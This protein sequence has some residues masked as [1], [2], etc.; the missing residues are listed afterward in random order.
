MLSEP[1]GIQ[2]VETAEAGMNVPDSGKLDFPALYRE[3][4]AIAGR[5]LRNRQSDQ[6][7]QP[8]ALVHEAYLKFSHSAF[9]ASDRTHLL[10]TASTIMRQILVDH[11]RSRQRLKR[12]PNFC[13]VLAESAD[14]I[15]PPVIDVLFVH[16]AISRLA[17]LDERQAKVVELKFFGGLTVTEIASALA[18]STKT[19]Q[20]D[21]DMAR[22]WLQRELRTGRD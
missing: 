9:S 10:C 22:A 21:W 18:I 5:H 4:H 7:L 2:L 14:L 12:G 20:R 11:A 15:A 19:V 17:A 16:E 13:R 6:T 8:T 1:I 3:L